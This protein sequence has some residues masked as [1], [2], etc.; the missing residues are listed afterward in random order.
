MA[1]N[2]SNFDSKSLQDAGVGYYASYKD[3]FG[4]IQIAWNVNSA[5][6]TSEPNRASRVL[7]Q[8]GMSF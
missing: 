4:Q 8:A 3:F 6:V 5:N 7:F 2:T 1:N